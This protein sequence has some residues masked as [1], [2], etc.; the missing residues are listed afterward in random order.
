MLMAGFIRH[1]QRG[2]IRTPNED[3][4]IWGKNVFP[5]GI[6]MLLITMVILG[7]FGWDGALRSGNWFLGILATILTVGLIWLSPRLRI[8][9]PVRAHWVKPE[10]ASWLDW[11]YRALWNLYRQMGRLANS[12]LS[13][14]E[15]ESGI[16]WT[17]L[18]L[19]LFI[20]VF[21][22]GTR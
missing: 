14:L 9:N 18:F 19:V 20:T 2:N 15:G 21:T 6:T 1:V 13:M 8:L 22:Q 7:L 5:I 3:Q 16:M 4:P 12:F 10:S 17:L 11:G